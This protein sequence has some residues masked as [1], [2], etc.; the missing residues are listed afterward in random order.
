MKSEL[1]E[2]MKIKSGESEKLISEMV[3]FSQSNF[4]NK[5]DREA[6]MHLFD[7]L[8][9]E[10]IDESINIKLAVLVWKKITA[11]RK[12]LESIVTLFID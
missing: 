10:E 8:S 12:K 3:H 7:Q 2:L 6:I 11:N 1:C 4:A 9:S 5:I